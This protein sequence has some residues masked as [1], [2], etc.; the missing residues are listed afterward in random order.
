MKMT[1]KKKRLMRDVEKLAR[2][3]LELAG[4][5]EGIPDSLA[6]IDKFIAGGIQGFVATLEIDG[7]PVKAAMD[8]FSAQKLLLEVAQQDTVIK[9]ACLGLGLFNCILAK[10][11]PVVRGALSIVGK[12][13]SLLKGLYFLRKA[14]YHGCYTGD[15]A[16]L[17]LIE[18]LSP[19][20]GDDAGEKK[21][22]LRTLQKNY[23]ENPYFV[24]L[25]LDE[26]ICFHT[27]GGLCI[28]IHRSCQT[29]DRTVQFFGL[30][31][32]TL[33]EPC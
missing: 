31:R 21:K 26:N 9:D 1:V 22:L 17:F 24:F 25:E 11:P 18:F 23:P 33:C 7:N 6:V 10:S 8:G 30:Q 12:D 28:F 20:M 19:Y 4:P 2:K 13:I 3:G 32:Q 5:A 29:A 15:I 14:A 16:R 27:G